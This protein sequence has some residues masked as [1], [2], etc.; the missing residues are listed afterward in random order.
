MIIRVVASHLQ[1]VPLISAG[2][3]LNFITSIIAITQV[4]VARV[5]HNVY[6]LYTFVI[7]IHVFEFTNNSVHWKHFDNDKEIISF[8]ITDKYTE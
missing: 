5:Q 8:M 6:L 7:E 4:W 3:R 1:S 2:V